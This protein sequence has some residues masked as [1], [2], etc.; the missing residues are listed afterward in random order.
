MPL[1]AQIREHVLNRC[2]SN[3]IPQL[4]SYQNGPDVDVSN[5]DGGEKRGKDRPSAGEPTLHLNA[6]VSSCSHTT[7]HLHTDAYIMDVYIT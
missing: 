1:R 6:L 7:V 3:L 5:R 4:E 2:S